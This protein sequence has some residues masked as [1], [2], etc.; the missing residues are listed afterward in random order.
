MKNRTY[1][2]IVTACALLSATSSAIG[3]QATFI[4]TI[5]VS[6]EY[7]DNVFLSYSDKEHDFITAVSPGFSFN[8]EGKKIGAES[9]Y[10]PTYSIYDE[11]SE[12]DTWR[13][14]VGF[15]GWA[16]ISK[17]NRIDIR[18]S[19]LR[20]EDPMSEIDST[21]R[22]NRQPYYTNTA[23][24]GLTHQFGESDVVYLEY[25]NYI[26]ENDDP[27]LE[28][29]ARHDALI[30]VTCWFLPVWGL[31]TGILY[32]KG[33]F[34]YSDDFDVWIANARLIRR[35]SRR[36]EVFMQYVHTALDYNGD[37]ADYQLYNPSIGFAYSP[38]ENL[39]LSFDVGHYFKDNTS[40]MD[41]DDGL[42]SN[43]DLS[44]T[45][46]RGSLRLRGSIG[47][48]QTSFGAENL[49][50]TIF[51]EAGG[52]ATYELTRYISGNIFG[53]YRENEYEAVVDEREDKITRCGLGFVIQPLA[54]M[55]I[56]LNYIYSY[57]DSTLTRDSYGENRA[58]LMVTLTPTRPYRMSQ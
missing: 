38:A 33:E 12:N 27:D 22:R 57:H 15:S 6:E 29:S 42:T 16:D 24:I 7:T 25:L 58:I 8:I 2:L 35:L 32:T 54:W 49:G 17:N 23:S 48:E 40:G 34:D 28:D 52:S 31:D 13:H 1:I 36:L 9:S 46:R 55:S 37:S 3:Y 4:P 30:N 51:Y 5:S 26:L 45:F 56:R 11:F 39:S 53:S 19:F 44:R 10:V 14:S 18:E 50:P 21:V 20:T 47:H 43:I 41:N